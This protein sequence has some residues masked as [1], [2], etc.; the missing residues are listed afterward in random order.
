MGVWQRQ[1]LWSDSCELVSKLTNLV[2]MLNHIIYELVFFD[3][4]L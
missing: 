1:E 2:F 4:V 3:K